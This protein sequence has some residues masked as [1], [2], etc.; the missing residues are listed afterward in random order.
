MRGKGDKRKGGIHMHT[1]TLMSPISCLIAHRL[2]LGRVVWD[3]R[4]LSIQ[5]AG[6]KRGQEEGYFR[7]VA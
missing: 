6:V 3:V 1:L 4:Y 2:A 7:V 5:I